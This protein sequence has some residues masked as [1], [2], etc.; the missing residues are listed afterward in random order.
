MKP[1]KTLGAA[2]RLVASYMEQLPPEDR[3][4]GLCSAIYNRRLDGSFT[5][6]QY[7]T[8]SQIVTEYVQANAQW[9]RARKLPMRFRTTVRTK[10]SYTTW[11]YPPGESWD[12]RILAAY[13]FAEMADAE[14]RQRKPS[15]TSH[16]EP[17]IVVE[18]L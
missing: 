5:Y 10:A 8:L 9:R 13:L 16:A 15:T 14:D 3:R 11:A 7:V 4:Y 17:R 6:L 2:W 18:Y 12:A 1:A